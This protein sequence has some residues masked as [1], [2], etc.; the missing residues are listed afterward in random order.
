MN[1]RYTKTKDTARLELLHGGNYLS[2]RGKGGEKGKEVY[3]GTW[4]V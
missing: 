3:E 1:E 2:S 4:Y